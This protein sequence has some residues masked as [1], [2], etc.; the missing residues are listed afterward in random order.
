MTALAQHALLGLSVAALGGAGLRVASLAAPSGLDRVLAAVTFAACAAVIQAVLLGLVGLGGSPLALAAAA[1]ATWLS[2][3]ALLPRPRNGAAFELRDWWARLAPRERIAIGALAGAGAAWAAW[4]LRY[5][6]LGYDSLLY[7]LS[8]SVTWAERGT[9]GSVEQIVNGLPVG[10]YPVTHEVLTAW[11]VGISGGFAPASLLPPA[12]A[13][14]TAAAGWYGLRALGVSRP[15][16]GLAAGALLACPAAIAYG[17]SGAAL[18]PAALAWLCTAAALAAGSLRR[19]AR[20]PFALVAAGMAAGT[21]TT[22]LPLA[23]TVVVIALVA[24]RPHLARMRKPLV[25]AAAAGLAVSATWYLRNLIQHGSPFWPFLTLPGGDEAPRAVLEAKSSFLDRPG[26]TVERLDR[27]YLEQFAGGIVL[28]LGALLAPL[29]ARRRSV[30][31]AALATAVS[32]LLW[33]NAPQTG[34]SG[35]PAFDPGTADAVRYLLPGLGAAALTLALAASS[36]GRARI[37]ALATLGLALAFNLVQA[38]G[39]GFPSAPKAT[40]VL[41]GAIAGAILA[42][43]WGRVRLP[44]GVAARLNRHPAPA[45]ATAALVL[46]C[47]AAP[48]ASGYLDRRAEMGQWDDGLVRWFAARHDDER[49]VG[50]SGAVHALLP[51]DRL[52]RRVTLI[53]GRESCAAVTRRREKSWVV[54]TQVLRRPGRTDVRDCFPGERPSYADDDF[55]IF[56][57][58]PGDGA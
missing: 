21:K 18:D 37:F 9:P 47:L 35:N 4:L 43:L 51:G 52:Q 28:L 16:T 29:V 45:A 10:A 53:P 30:A 13:A 49:A 14:L 38:F 3:R 20:L 17:R 2:C 31:A 7:H 54:F 42:V 46:G 44:D 22:A 32:L 5:P 25:L 1:C 27:L 33:L 58:R 41:A 23:L 11:A 48:V 15:V 34:V 56:A 55:Q 40:T 6:V 19:P 12:V 39:L 36:G 8:E 50:I 57:P 24:C 26:Q